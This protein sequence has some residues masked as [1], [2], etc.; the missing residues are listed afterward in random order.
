MKSV[1]FIF[2]SEDSLEIYVYKWEPEKNINIKGVIQI[3]HGMAETAARYEGFA[4]MLTENGYIVYINDHRGHGKTAKN[5]ENVGY[6]AE[7]DGFEWLVKDMHTLTGIIKKENKDLPIFLLGYSMGSFLTQRYIM[8]YGKELKGAILYG[9]NGRQGLIL[10]IGLLVSKLEI[11]KNGVKAKS[12][13]LNDLI[14]GGYNKPFKPN[15]TKFDWLNRNNEEVDKYI[16]DPFCG[17]VFTCSFYYD[18]FKCLIEIENK[19][20]LKT[21]P[22][23]LPIY[24]FSGGKDPVGKSGKG[25]KRL[26]ET[27][28]SLGVKDLTFK[29]YKDGRHDMLNEI[30]KDEVIEDVLAWLSRYSLKVL[31]TI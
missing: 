8:L 3:A 23:D 4:K 29:L 20:N 27:Y 25:V 5:I 10:R 24:I 12:Q 22:R 13:I 15:R 16:K 14:F 30:N 31:K 7:K 26:V 21:V 18:F 17:T 19:K 28:K 11:K 9:S 6:L 2:K 1:N